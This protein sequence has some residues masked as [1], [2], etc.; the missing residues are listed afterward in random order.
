MYLSETAEKVITAYG[1]VARWK[2]AKKI[3]AEVSV[4]GL[5]FV[6]KQRSFFSRARIIQHIHQPFSRLTPIG[7]KPGISGILDGNDVRLEDEHHEM[8]SERKD[9]RDYFKLNRRIFYW[10]DLDM[11]YF[12]N[13]AFW[14]YFTLPSLLMRDDI[15]WK[16]TRLGQL[17]ARFPK[18]I[19]THC[20]NQHF[21]FDPQTGLLIQH[22]YT[23]DIISRFASAANVVLKHAKNSQG[24]IYTASRRVT[25]MGMNGTG[26][27]YPVLIQIEVDDFQLI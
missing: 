12:A 19:P 23:A 25:P 21:R 24:M 10:D 20:R 27:K 22:N 3:E 8:I 26:L 9:P 11:A 18:E 17:E 14:N 5:A 13:Y 2:Q 6:L 15:I 4:T 16:E 1:G 7:R